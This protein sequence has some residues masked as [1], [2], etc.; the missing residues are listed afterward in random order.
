MLFLLFLF[1][2]FLVAPY[3][4]FY[5]YTSTF[6]VMFTNVLFSSQIYGSWSVVGAGVVD[7]NLYQRMEHSWIRLST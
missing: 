4:F 3:T 5:I 7:E 1:L 6:I 2:C